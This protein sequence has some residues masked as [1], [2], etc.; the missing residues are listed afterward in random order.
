MTKF[1]GNVFQRGEEFLVQVS[2]WKSKVKAE[3]EHA[4]FRD[5]GYA[6]ELVEYHSRELGKYHRVMIGGFKSYDE[7]K[8][9][10]KQKK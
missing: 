3:S 10:L 5:A 7:A 8:E 1:R 2:S 9:F 4:K 6:A